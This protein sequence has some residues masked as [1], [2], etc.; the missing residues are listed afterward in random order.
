MGAKA[1]SPRVVLD[2]NVI[3][4]ALL[5]GGSVQRLVS[6]WQSRA[7]VLLLTRPLLDEYLQVLA[8]PKFELTDKEIRALV[9]EELLP[10]VEVVV[11]TA[12]IRVPRLKDRDDEKFLKAAQSGNADFLITG[13]RELANLEK[14]GKCRI[15]S[16]ADFLR[17]IGL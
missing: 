17:E 11:E 4:S 5:F 9:D 8:Y 3:V 16:P 13:D 7:F 14:I 1:L 15:L 2:T 12:G 6:L 10:F